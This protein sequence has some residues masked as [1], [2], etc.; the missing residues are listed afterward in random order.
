MTF[1]AA[2]SLEICLYSSDEDVS[3]ID[4]NVEDPDYEG[5]SSNDSFFVLFCFFTVT[6]LKI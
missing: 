6:L 4:D 5:S 3:E 2:K 1:S